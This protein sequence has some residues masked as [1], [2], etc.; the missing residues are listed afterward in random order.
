MMIVDSHFHAWAPDSR[1]AADRS[2]APAEV[3][4]IEDALAIQA[5][6]GVTHGVMIQPS[7]LGTDNAYI[8]DCLRARPD[9]LRATVVVG[10][11]IP[12]KDLEAISGFAD[13]TGA[14]PSVPERLALVDVVVL[15][16]EGDVVVDIEVRV[17]AEIVFD[18]VGVV[19]EAFGK[20]FFARHSD[21][22]VVFALG[23]A[24]PDF[25][26]GHVLCPLV[27]KR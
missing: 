6:H 11:D 16:E 1:L 26:T 10:P 2:Y 8:L 3:K 15:A 4:T 9:R 20:N 5:G 14:A 21:G 12:E 13:R 7:F 22:A 27:N 19:V 17:L 24:S 23:V 25:W 18:L